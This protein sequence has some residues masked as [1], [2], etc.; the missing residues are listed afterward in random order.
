MF[1]RDYKN[2]ATEI[3]DKYGYDY[4]SFYIEFTDIKDKQL[5]WFDYKSNQLKYINHNILLNYTPEYTSVY[6]K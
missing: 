3:L 2:V 4:K 6:R 1:D 5:E